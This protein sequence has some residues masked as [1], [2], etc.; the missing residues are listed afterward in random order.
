MAKCMQ[1][2][3]REATVRWRCEMV[4]GAYVERKKTRVRVAVVGIQ[5]LNAENVARK[6]CG[7]EIR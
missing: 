5:M 4:S 2:E 6:K 1:A 3:I 7:K